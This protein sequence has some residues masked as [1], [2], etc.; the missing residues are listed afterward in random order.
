VLK[1][2]MSAN[3]ASPEFANGMLTFS[4]VAQVIEEI[5]ERYGRFQDREC[6][7][8]KSVLM[9]MEEPGT[10]RVLLKNFYG[11][12]L[13]GNF[14]FTENREYLREL[15]ALDETEPARE[16]VI[17]ANYINAASNCGASTGVYSVCCINECEGLLGHLEKEIA[18]PDATPDR[19]IE[20]VTH[21]PSSTV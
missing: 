1:E 18:E 10:G 12:A 13:K 21:L 11:D 7:D 6:K 2:V 9:S 16:S 15:G 5:G 4:A 17:I 19:I 8:L 3:S 14:A 20:V